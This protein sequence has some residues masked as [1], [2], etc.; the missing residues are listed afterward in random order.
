MK[1]LLT[2]T[3]FCLCSA[4][5]VAQTTQGNRFMSFTGDLN[6]R[7]DN[8]S[9]SLTPE[10]KRQ[11][12]GLNL[13]MTRGKFTRDNIAQGWSI[14]LGATHERINQIDYAETTPSLS[15]HYVYRRYIV[16]SERVRLFAQGKAGGLYSPTFN[17]GETTQNTFSIGASLDLGLTYFYRKNW[18]WEATASLA[19]VGVSHASAR[20]E[21]VY[22]DVNVNGSLG[23]ST[24]R[25]GLAHYFG[26][27]SSPFESAPQ[28]SLYEVGQTYL[29]GDLSV[30]QVSARSNTTNLGIGFAAGKFVTPRRLL[31]ISVSGSY[32]TGVDQG[33]AD[34]TNW[35]ASV[36]PYAEQYWPVAGKWTVLLDGGVALGYAQ[37]KT[38]LNSVQS[39]TQ[40]TYYAKPTFRPGIQYQLTQRWALAAL[41]GVL[42][43]TGFTATQQE[44]TTGNT[45]SKSTIYAFTIDPSYQISNSSLSLRYFPGR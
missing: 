40:T 8:T 20:G 43:L 36:R 23:F 9:S 25:I 28:Q 5:L 35:G 41:V 21:K 14:G 13:Q 26:E 24:F 22:T 11:T 37:V 34:Y 31:G 44:V 29:A 2:A 45:V 18:A 17:D 32:G 42:D 15:A 7:F 27:S 10:T 38:E 1:Q 6:L 39:N 16:P 30:Q 4:S 3:F 19:N 33:N 12:Y